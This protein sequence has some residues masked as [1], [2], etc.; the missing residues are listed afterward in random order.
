MEVDLDQEP[1]PTEDDRLQFGYEK[2][3]VYIVKDPGKKPGEKQRFRGDSVD[4]ILGKFSDAYIGFGYV[5]GELLMDN[6]E[7]QEN[8][9]V[10]VFQQEAVNASIRPG[11]EWVGNL[12][13]IEQI[14]EEVSDSSY[15]VTVY[16]DEKITSVDRLDEELAQASVQSFPDI[17]GVQ[18][19]AYWPQTRQ[20]NL[21]Q[22]NDRI[23]VPKEPLGD[24]RGGL[25]DTDQEFETVNYPVDEASIEELLENHENWDISR[26]KAPSN[27]IPPEIYAEHYGE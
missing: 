7:E 15:S 20:A 10:P 8:V 4:E 1:F 3:R 9:E 5:N 22:Y 11:E 19:I 17:K 14:N 2:N 12:E 21:I 16:N 24:E 18:V 6:Q 23:R 13:D 26:H 25:I 27:E